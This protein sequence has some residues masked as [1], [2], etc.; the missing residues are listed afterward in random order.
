MAT[1]YTQLRYLVKILIMNKKLKEFTEAY[2]SATAETKEFI[3]SNTI[4]LFSEQILNNTSYHSIRQKL[5]VILANRFLEIITN[6]EVLSDL[7]TA[8]ISADTAIEIMPKIKS[9]IEQSQKNS[10]TRSTPT[11]TLPDE[12][13]EA[14][15]ALNSLRTMNTDRKA[16]EEATFPSQ[17]DTILTNKNSSAPTNSPRWGSES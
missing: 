8:G 3:D 11:K 5:I 10:L 16:I 13:A 6:E 15:A 14:E 17:Q 2:S 7:L 4:G 9:F 1:L 12:I